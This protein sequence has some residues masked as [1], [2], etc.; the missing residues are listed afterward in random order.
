MRWPVDISNRSRIVSRSRKQY[1][2]IEIAPRSSA[3]VPEPHEVAHDPVE[4]HVDHAQVLGALGDLEV[5]QRL[6][7]AAER[8]RVEEV[9]EVVHPLDDG[10]G[11]PVG[12]VLAGLL[13]AGVDVADDRLDVADDLAVERRDQAQHAV[14][15][16][17]VR[18]E[19]EGQQLVVRAPTG[20]STRRRSVAL[21]GRSTSVGHFHHPG[22]SVSLCVK[23][24]GSPPIG[25]SRRCG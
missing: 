13:D 20:R 16:G 2:N 10:D 23:S 24:T 12:L 18:A 6:R 3:L 17:V 4:L 22:L 19:V 8:V 7:R 9:G 5:D 25:K 21:A 15:G 14:G 1:Q 11:L